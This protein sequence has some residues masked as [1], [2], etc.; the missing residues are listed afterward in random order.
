[1][2]ENHTAFINRWILKAVCAPSRTKEFYTLEDAVG[3]KFMVDLNQ[4]GHSCIQDIPGCAKSDIW[5]QM[6][7]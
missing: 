6:W 3:K 2:K 4:P 5:S 1:M 7:V